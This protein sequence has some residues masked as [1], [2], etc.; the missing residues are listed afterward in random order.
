M[1]SKKSQRR[2]APLHE[3]NFEDEDA[4]SVSQDEGSGE[5][6]GEDKLSLILK[7]IREMREEN[8]KQFGDLKQDIA[9]TNVRLD[10]VE[11]RFV[12]ID[13]RVQGAEDIITELVKQQVPTSTK[14][15]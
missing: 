2:N 14:S 10:E 13:D 5:A 8:K 9:Q 1:T 4:N 3:K 12:T 15:I 6:G 7:E 11:Q